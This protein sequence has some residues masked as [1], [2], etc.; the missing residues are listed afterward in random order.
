MPDSPAESSS[1]A[2]TPDKPTWDIFCRVIDNYGDLGVCLRLARD[3]AQRGAQARLWSDDLSPLAWMQPEPVEGL[4][5][6]PWA[7]SARAEPGDVVV[8][9]F[10]CE[11]PEAFVAA[12]AARPVTPAWI[13]L[14]YLSAESYVERSHGLR[15]PQFSGPGAGLE[16]RFFYPGFN[17]R[18]GGLLREPGL[19]EAATSHHGDAWLA[20]RGWGRQPGERVLSLFAYPR[21]PLAEFLEALGPG[22]LLLLCPGA[23]QAEA[24]PLLRTGQRAIALPHL[25]QADYDRLLWSCDL[26]LVRGEDS[27]VR[28]QWAGQPMLWQIYFQDDGAHGPKLEAFL[29]QSLA[30]APEALRTNWSALSR[31][32]NGLAPWTS[33]AADAL[34][35]L[36]AATAH[37][38]AWRAELGGQLDLSSRLQ[39]F[40]GL[41][42][43]A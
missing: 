33:Q 37:A 30:G 36:T 14:E 6:R 18:T 41:S 2:Q 15:S 25:S 43:G 5:C 8:E 34:R 31:A 10:G 4:S 29:A 35:E 9:T 27:F 20:T 32:W 19:I 16:K 17:E 11:L 39:A 22:W 38:R 23:P 28:A 3:L 21:A 26:N 13:N 7:D 12:M 40:A 1:A 42:S 24:P